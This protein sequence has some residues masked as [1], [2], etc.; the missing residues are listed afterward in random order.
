M[1]EE[2]R[3]LS[4]GLQKFRNFL[5]GRKHTLTHR[6]PKDVSCRSP[7]LP[8]LPDGPSHKLSNN[9]YFSRDPRREIKPPTVVY[10]PQI[11]LE[12]TG[13]CPQKL[14]G[15]RKPGITYNWDQ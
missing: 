5:F 9:Y 2:I 8:K 13:E 15:A 7:P 11:S 12:K 3:N 10:V 1:T 4:L 14:I 6:Y